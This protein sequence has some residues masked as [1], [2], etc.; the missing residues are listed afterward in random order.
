MSVRGVFTALA[1]G[2]LCTASLVA[3]EMPYELGTAGA[4]SGQAAGAGV[5]FIP[6]ATPIVGI[7]KAGAAEGLA[8]GQFALERPAGN[9]AVP[10]SGNFDLAVNFNVPGGIREGQNGLFSAN[11]SGVVNR[12][13]GWVSV[14]F[15]PARTFTF[16][17]SYGSGSFRFGVEGVKKFVAGPDRSP[18]ARLVGSI[19]RANFTP[20]AE[21]GA[22]VPEPSA[23]LLLLSGAFGMLILRRRLSES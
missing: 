4:F 12:N 3:D 23:V 11:L 7:T 14:D 9:P 13:N 16:S 2:I 22:P 8:L 1:I 18:E 6:A 17:N 19:S 21:S 20:A 10:H 15:G 5:R